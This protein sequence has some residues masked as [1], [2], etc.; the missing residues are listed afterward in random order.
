MNGARFRRPIVGNSFDANPARVEGGLGAV[1]D[2]VFELERELM[3]TFAKTESS[4]DI[5]QLTCRDARH[6]LL[7]C[8]KQSGLVHSLP[9]D[10]DQFEEKLLPGFYLVRAELIE[11][12]QIEVVVA[13]H[14]GHVQLRLVAVG[15]QG[16]IPI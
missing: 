16:F 11:R 1:Q 10:L 7:R 9:D 14:C 4:G 6:R 13:F 12:Y 5:M 15:A 8:L 2:S 3:V